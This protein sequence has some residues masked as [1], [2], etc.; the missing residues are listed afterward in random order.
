MKCDSRF[1][2]HKLYCSI[3]IHIEGEVFLGYLYTIVEL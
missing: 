3:S 1:E 2:Y